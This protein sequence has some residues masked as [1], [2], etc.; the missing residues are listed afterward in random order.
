VLIV[1]D[2]KAIEGQPTS[3]RESIARRI[4]E[5]ASEGERDR[6]NLRRTGFAAPALRPINRIGRHCTRCR[7]CTR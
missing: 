5:L 3:V 4:I 2:D 1:A 7:H 6:D